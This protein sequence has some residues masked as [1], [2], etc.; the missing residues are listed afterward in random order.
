M[1][2]QQGGHRSVEVA[3]LTFR[4]W[5]VC[6]RCHRH[7]TT[8]D[9]ILRSGSELVSLSDRLLR[10]LARRPRAFV[11]RASAVCIAR[12]GA[13]IGRLGAP[14]QSR[15]ASVLTHTWMQMSP[16]STVP[17]HRRFRR[18]RSPA[19]RNGTGQLPLARRRRLQTRAEHDLDAYMVVQAG[20]TCS[21]GR[22]CDVQ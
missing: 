3:P 1:H 5:H 2:R 6:A 8:L 14:L 15:W 18:P 7:K 21:M 12:R 17:G 9:A 22:T 13:R 16:R 11:T 19:S 4:G 20:R 10:L